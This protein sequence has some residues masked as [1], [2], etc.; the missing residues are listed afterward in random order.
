M[1]QDFSEDLDRARN[2][3][4]RAFARLIEPLRRELHAHC[5]RMLGSVHDADDALQLT[6][7]R[8]W[9]GL[10]RFEGRSPV[11]T[12]LY[13]TA[14]RV[15]LDLAETR[16]RRAVPVDLGPASAHPILDSQPRADVAWLTPYAS[17]PHDRVER[18]ETITLAFVAALQHLAPNQR[19]A[20]LLFEV[21][22]F[23]AA[24]IAGIMRTSATSVNSALAR[25]RRVLAERV[26]ASPP[27]GGTD[28]AVRR[29]ASRFAAALEAGDLDTFVSLLTRDVTW[30]MPPL[31]H[32]YAGAEAVARFAHEMPM[33]RCP[34]WQWRPVTANGQ[35]AI[36]FYL[37]ADPGSSHEAWSITVLE[38]RDGLVGAISS[39]LDPDLFPAFE[40]PLALPG[41]VTL[42]R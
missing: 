33:T 7:T 9:R 24:E 1:P 29:L 27:Q 15:C 34:S 12:W 21:L 4:E 14:T 20:L 35:P 17:G 41:R 42:R 3:D 26:P 22:D 25:A 6:W 30:T 10:A 38:V 16:G 23:S 8:A 31:P 37:G 2:G 13:T 39:F 32:W 18:A 40:L 28:P 19:A 11:R 36:A 5:Y